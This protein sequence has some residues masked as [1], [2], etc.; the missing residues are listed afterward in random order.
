M[1]MTSSILARL[2]N[3]PSGIKPAVQTRFWTQWRQKRWLPCAAEWLVILAVA[4]LYGGHFLLN[5]DGQQLQQTGEHNESATLPLLA[6]IGLWRYGEIPLWN[7]YMLTGFPHAGDLINHFWNPVSTIPV[8]IWG[9][10]NG[11]KVSIFV[12]FV[13]AGMGQ[14]LFAHIFG[15]RSWFRL[16]AALLF[17]LSGGLALLWRLGWYELLLGAVWFP[18]CFASLWWALKRKD[19]TSLVLAAVC[20]AMVLTTGG[21]YYPVYLFVCLSVLAAAALLWARRSER[22]S[23]LRRAAAVA[24]LS[25]GLLA[26]MLLPL[27]D[28]Y[29]LTARDTLPDQQQ[30]GSQPIAYALFNYVVSAPEWL[31][32][33]VLSKGSGWSWFYIGFLPLAALTL[34][35]LAYSRARWHR[36]ALST[37]AVLFVVLLAWQA[38]RYFPVRF[39]YDWI[40]FLYTFRFPNRLLIIASSPLIVLAGLGLQYFMVEGRRWSRGWRLAVAQ[41]YGDRQ[42]SGLPVRWVLYG[43]LLL[44]MALSLRDVYRVNKGFAFADQRL[45]AK[46]YTALK[47]LKQYDPDLYYTSLGGDAVFWDWV[48]AG[49]E[50]EMPIINFRYNR[51]LV[52]MADQRRPESP[53]F[54]TPKYFLARPD[55]SKPE[56]AELLNHF[57]GVDL[58]FLP[59]ALPVAFSAD[60]G[61]LLSSGSLKKETV[62]PL[63]VRYD[64]P[65]QIVVQGE[66]G[67]VGD[68]LVVLVSNYPGWRLFVDGQPAPLQPAN[69]YL[70][71]MMPGGEHTYT[72]VFRPSKHVIGLAISLLTLAAMLAILLVESPLGA[73]L[74]GRRAGRT[75]GLPD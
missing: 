18:W 14:W 10:I 5:F 63:A 36:P 30:L 23:K 26:V 15:L 31:N 74:A 2:K 8:L 1:H 42:A 11:M 48:P 45:N 22:W 56:N 66:P 62:S 67:Q 25:L 72:F 13:L 69:D 49:Y 4:Y 50:L 37:L 53:F 52:S 71:A 41:K 51:R 61:L 57:D 35:P 44:I 28:G 16:W 7:P 29:R 6:E 64:G 43:A 9:G 3:W 65:N 54:A 17:M 47:W 55:Q 70:G 60:P 38:N 24:A 32:V 73:R 20:V 75:N 68:Q 33:D 58:W 40:P 12:S 21:G 34:I 27:V 59:D 46:S 19:R 39:L